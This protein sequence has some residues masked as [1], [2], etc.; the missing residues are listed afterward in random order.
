[1]FSG[2]LFVL[3]KAE[4]CSREVS[5]ASVLLPEDRA[6]DARWNPEELERTC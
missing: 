2:K 3:A 5:V 6:F 4:G 1:L